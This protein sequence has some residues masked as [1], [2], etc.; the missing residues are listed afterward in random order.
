MKAESLGKRY[1]LLDDHPS[2]RGNFAQNENGLTYLKWLCAAGAIS[3][4]G[5][6][7]S[8]WLDKQTLTDSSHL[9]INFS[10][11]LRR[12][13]RA[14]EDPT[15]YRNTFDDDWRRIEEHRQAERTKIRARYAANR[16]IGACK[17]DDTL[18]AIEAHQLA[19][20]FHVSYTY[21]FKT[22]R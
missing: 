3:T 13:W 11:A 6:R 19:G 10:R 1:P 4:A 15:E 14:G 5:V 2:A 8:S 22:K 9:R 18:G 12:A 7:I 17:E 20:D 16:L 21:R